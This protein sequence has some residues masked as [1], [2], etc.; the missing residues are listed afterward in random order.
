MA[1]PFSIN[2]VS[3][4]NGETWL[5][6]A[7]LYVNPTYLLEANF[8]KAMHAQWENIKRHHADCSCRLCL[9]AYLTHTPKKHDN[10]QADGDGQSSQMRVM[11]GNVGIGESEGGEQEVPEAFSAERI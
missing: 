2:T 3:Q 1:Q 5:K 7:K 8:K 9:V 11:A 10:R 4:V 6:V